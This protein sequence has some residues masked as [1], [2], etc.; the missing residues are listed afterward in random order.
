MRRRKLTL[1]ARDF[2]VASS[3]DLKSHVTDANGPVLFATQAEAY[4][5]SARTVSCEPG[6]GRDIA[7]R[8]AF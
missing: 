5:R 8:I 7:G 2:A 6:A 1:P 3:V 4:Q